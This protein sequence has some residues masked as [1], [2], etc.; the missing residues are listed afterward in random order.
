V[1]VAVGAGVVGVASGAGLAGGVTVT[2]RGT[3]AGGGATV[4]VFGDGAAALGA[5]A[6]GDTGTVV[7]LGVPVLV[8]EG[9][10]AGAGFDGPSA[11]GGVGEAGAGL[12]PSGVAAGGTTVTVGGDI[13]AGG[14][15]G[16]T[17]AGG[18]DG[19][20]AAGS[21]GSSVATGDGD[22]SSGKRLRYSGDGGGEGPRT[23]S[24][25]REP[26]SDV[27]AVDRGGSAARRG[28]SGIVSAITVS[29]GPTSSRERRISGGVSAL[30]ATPSTDL[31]GSRTSAR[32]GNDAGAG[33]TG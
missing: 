25:D 7:V 21:G 8:A 32:S 2:T 24:A 23:A 16:D 18:L 9:A 10:G 26:R 30:A 3:A 28:R 14:L 22:V 29:S 5:G 27:D 13:C 20:G 12:G 31:R 6:V 1:V 15:G 19:T 33:S 17:C 11:G 4:T